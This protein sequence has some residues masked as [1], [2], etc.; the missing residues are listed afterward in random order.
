MDSPRLRLPLPDYTSRKLRFRILA[1]TDPDAAAK[2]G[3]YATPSSRRRG[4]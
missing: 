3:G 2:L 1:R 4:H